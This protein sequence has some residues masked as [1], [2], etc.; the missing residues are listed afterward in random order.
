MDNYTCCQGYMDNTCFKAGNCGEKSCPELC[1]CLETHCCVGPSMSSSRMFMMDKYDLRSDPCDN[2]MIRLT[3]CIMML[4]CVFDILAL[5]I[6]ELKDAAH[7]LRTIANCIFYSML[8]CMAAQ[9]NN[10]VDVR[11][12]QPQSIG[13]AEPINPKSIQYEDQK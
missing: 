3:N 5:A 1:L 7:I 9:V 6:K 10:E 8:G 11:K 4:A 12:N 2:R 13:I